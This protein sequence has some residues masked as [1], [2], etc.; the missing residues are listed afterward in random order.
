MRVRA[1]R[2]DVPDALHD[3]LA[4]SPSDAER[5]P[6]RAA[7][8]G[9]LVA[10]LA[11]LAIGCPA[12]PPAATTPTVELPATP[13]IE[14]AVVSTPTATREHSPVA[15][16]NNASRALARARR[17]NR[18]VMV[19]VYADW[20]VPS[21]RAKRE[22]WTDPRVVRAARPFVPLWLDVTTPDAAAEARVARFGSARPPALMVVDGG[23]SRVAELKGTLDVA[24]VL[25]LLARAARR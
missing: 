24:S 21:V 17:E 3:P 6:L 4:A 20:N 9:V 19:F 1:E 15:W 2:F 8:R 18:L 5:K 14:T 23:A 7:R 12:E 22:L 10:S 25:E 11:W 16:E 13:S